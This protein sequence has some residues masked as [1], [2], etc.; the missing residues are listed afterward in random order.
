MAASALLQ[1]LILGA[2]MIIPIGAQNSYILSQGI[3]RNH[4]I[5]AATICMV[6]DVALIALGI[7]GGG[8]LIA[9]HEWLMLSI[10]WGG[11]L[12]LSAYAI[13]SFKQVWQNTYQV[14]VNATALNSR[15][16]IIGATFAVTLLN[17]HVYLDTVM[18]LGSVGGK[19]DGNEKLAFALGTMLASILWFYSLAFGAAKMAPWL[20][21]PKVQRIIDA[22]VGIIMLVIAYSLFSSLKI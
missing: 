13:F 20:G 15:K 16:K 9:S 22:L 17:P 10:G 11:V 1:G 21:A 2:G 14:A 8:K 5:L 7:F 12:F 4:H 6:C 3:K 19:F 18:I